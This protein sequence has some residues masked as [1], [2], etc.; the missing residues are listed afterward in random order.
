MKNEMWFVKTSI[1]ALAIGASAFTCGGDDGN[2]P[3]PPPPPPP[4]KPMLTAV[5][6][7]VDSPLTHSEVK[8]PISFEITVEGVTIAPASEQELGKGY[9]V[10]ALDGRCT[11]VNVEIPKDGRHVHLLDGESSPSVNLPIG[12]REVCVQVAYGDGR[13]YDGSA[14]LTLYVY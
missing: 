3:E 9:F 10:F 1:L 5:K 12:M 13:A 14:S 11:P 2:D 4:V 6:I 8:N 7:T